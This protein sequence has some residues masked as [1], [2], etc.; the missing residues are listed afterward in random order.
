MQDGQQGQQAIE[1]VVVGHR[2]A[3]HLGALDAAGGRITQ[4]FSQ[5]GSGADVAAAVQLG[6][7]AVMQ[8]WSCCF[9]DHLQRLLTN[10][11]SN[12]CGSCCVTIRATASYLVDQMT[13]MGK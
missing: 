10:G 2:L 12:L 5:H 4:Y 3:Q 6:G 7:L 1:E 8:M 13:Q 9:P 11:L